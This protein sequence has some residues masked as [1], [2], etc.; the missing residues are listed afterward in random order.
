ALG[1]AEADAAHVEPAPGAV[2]PTQA[3]ARGPAVGAPLHRRT[4]ALPHGGAIVGVDRVEPAP[5]AGLLLRL[6]REARPRGLPLDEGAGR[7]SG[8]DDRRRR[9]DEGPVARLAPPERLLGPDV[10]G[11]VP[12]DEDG[13]ALVAQGCGRP[14][15]RADLAVG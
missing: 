5:A 12:R 13:T 11:R 15:Q 9:L 10:L 1:L 7:A 8:E 6:A 3:V 2:A 4:P 14:D